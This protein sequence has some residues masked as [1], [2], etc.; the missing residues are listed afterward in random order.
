MAWPVA[1]NQYDY[2]STTK[3][4]APE[5]KVRDFAVTRGVCWGEF[6]AWLSLLPLGG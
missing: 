3:G 4:G 2:P 1:G 5:A 6:G